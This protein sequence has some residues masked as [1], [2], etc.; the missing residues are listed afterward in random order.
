M[1]KKEKIGFFKKIF[2][3]ITDF[4]IY[5]FLVKNEKLLKSFA[6]LIS[7]VLT[8]SF[9][10]SLNVFSKIKEGVNELMQNYNSIMPEFELSNGNLNVSETIYEKI[11]ENFYLIVDTNHSYDEIKSTKEYEKT[12]I[13]DD[14]AIITAKG[15]VIEMNGEAQYV[16]EFKNL[17]YELNKD[18]LFIELQNYSSNIFYKLSIYFSVYAS[19][20]I[21]YFIITL[22]RIIFIA[23]I[24]SFI[25]LILGIYL[26]FSNYIK[27]AIY[28]HTLPLII[29][30]ISL[31]L[32]GTIKD[33]AYYTSLILTYVYIIYAIRAIKLDAFL[34][35]V[36]SKKNMSHNPNE[37]D[38]ELKKYN[39]TVNNDKNVKD[40]EKEDDINKE[41]KDDEN[42]K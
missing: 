29:E 6:Y 17:D 8:V 25:S 10:L 35:M 26:K 28:T 16:A 36:S 13:Y 19:I 23:F 27:I 11:N 1:E 5:P 32:V 42:K 30:I 3:V 37:F 31:C 2:L 24:I 33:Y 20:C 9:I 22:I 14:L 4:R 21:A 7:L 34:I 18:T 40:E 39:S 38:N 41:D 12:L 15:I